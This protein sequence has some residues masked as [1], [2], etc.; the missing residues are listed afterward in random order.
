MAQ[1]V[2][3]PLPARC[4]H[5]GLVGCPCAERLIEQWQHLPKAMAGQ[6]AQGDGDLYDDLLGVANLA[7]CSAA[8]RWDATR[9]PRGWFPYAQQAIRWEILMELRRRGRY[10]QKQIQV[11]VAAKQAWA[12]G[13]YVRQGDAIEEEE[14]V[15]HVK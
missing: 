9:S 3:R 4:A 1:Q 5:C 14:V 2:S 7:L 15:G 12:S 11:I 8:G 6:Y 13:H 10:S